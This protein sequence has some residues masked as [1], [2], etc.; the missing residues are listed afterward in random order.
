VRAAHYY[1]DGVT[2]EVITA[3]QREVDD[4][5]RQEGYT[6]LRQWAPSWSPASPT[7]TRRN[8]RSSRRTGN[9]RTGSQRC[10]SGWFRLTGRAIN[11]AAA[12][13]RHPLDDMSLST[14]ALSAN[15]AC[16]RA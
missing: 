16:Q 6:P 15:A 7:G 11:P 12:G 9:T 5:L 10:R 2:V 4:E 13:V 8:H 1:P 14:K 3:L